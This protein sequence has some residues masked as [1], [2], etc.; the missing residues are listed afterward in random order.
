MSELP[1]RSLR[2]GAADSPPA[3]ATEMRTRR[4]RPLA[5]L[6]LLALAAGITLIWL[7]IPMFVADA[8]ERLREVIAGTG[9]FAPAAFVVLASLGIAAG[10]PR[11]VF[12]LTAGGL[13]GALQ[14]VLLAEAATVIGAIATFRLA[15]VAGREAALRQLTRAGRRE[16]GSA[17]IPGRIE[18]LL[19]LIADHP[20]ISNLVLRA[21]PVGN[22]LAMNLFMSLT[23]IRLGWFTL[24]TALGTLPETV[25]CGLI[26]AGIVETRPGPWFTAGLLFA[27]LALG[28]WTLGRRSK[29]VRELVLNLRGRATT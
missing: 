5:L 4:T 24:G 25:I 20:L 6:S 19:Q 17:D 16:P 27:A 21:I 7:L 18:P 2:D 13:F 14:G 1:L 10:A 8:P 12:A 9:G 29:L 28:Y 3:S 26:G 23:S 15:R 22:C 11:L